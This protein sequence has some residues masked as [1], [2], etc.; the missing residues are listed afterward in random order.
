MNIAILALFA[1]VIFLTFLT[2]KEVAKTRYRLTHQLEQVAL[3][4]RQIHQK[5]HP[6]HL[7]ATEIR[8]M[9]TIPESMIP[10]TPVRGRGKEGTDDY[11]TR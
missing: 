2:M 4:I 1:I 8:G 6:P 3:Q 9:G 10:T 5:L 7:S 11:G